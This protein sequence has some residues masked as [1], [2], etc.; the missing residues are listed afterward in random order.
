MNGT[1]RRNLGFRHWGGRRRQRYLAHAGTQ[2]SHKSRA[3]QILEPPTDRADDL[4]PDVPLFVRFVHHRIVTCEQEKT[5]TMKNAKRTKNAR[6]S[7]S[8][9]G[10][11]T[12]A[13]DRFGRIS[14][15]RFQEV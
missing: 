15:I 2:D 3:L 14:L 9:S 4:E 8:E 1:H 11:S 7:A 12:R 10:R 6:G 5:G 13:R